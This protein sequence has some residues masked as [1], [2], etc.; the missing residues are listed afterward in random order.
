MFV[1]LTD[2]YSKWMNIYSMYDIKT[3]FLIDAL[4]T[5][6]A[7]QGLLYVIDIYTFFSL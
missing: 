2:T 6:F 5:S 3:V 7:T 4:R 1:V